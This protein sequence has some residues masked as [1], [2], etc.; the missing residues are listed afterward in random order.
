VGDTVYANGPHQ[1]EPVV[2][3]GQH[4]RDPH[5]GGFNVTHESMEPLRQRLSMSGRRIFQEILP[6]GRVRSFTGLRSRGE[7]HGQMVSFSSSGS[8]QPI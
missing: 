2:V 1:G 4:Q 3:T 6:D 8:C 5:T 7:L